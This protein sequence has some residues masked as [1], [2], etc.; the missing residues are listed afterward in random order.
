MVHSAR[1]DARRPDTPAA[2]KLVHLEAMRGIA[3]CFVVFFHF[4]MVFRLNHTPDNV[5][6]VNGIF[7]VS[8]FFALSGYVLSLGKVGVRSP[9]PWLKAAVKR[10]PRLAL[11]ALASVL[12][13]AA[14]VRQPIAPTPAIIAA[15]APPI[16][17]E[18][19]A[20]AGD[21]WLAAYQGVV[22]AFAFGISPA[23]PALWT[24]KVELIGSLGLFAGCWAAAWLGRWRWILFAGVATALYASALHGYLAFLLGRL[25]HERAFSATHIPAPLRPT[26][27][28]IASSLG[29]VLSSYPYDGYWQPSGPFFAKESPLWSFMP[30]VR[31]PFWFW[32]VIGAWLLLW[33]F[34]NAPAVSRIFSGWLSAWLGRL[35]FSI[36]LVHWPILATFVVFAAGKLKHLEYS[37][38]LAAT[39]AIFAVLTLAAS[40]P[41]HLLIDR[42]S[43]ALT[44][45][46]VARLF[47]RREPRPV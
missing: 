10:Y 33:V 37:L 3:A 40:V 46:V 29:V 25:L 16:V 23:N 47:R 36:Y 4:D 43:V 5:V 20:A 9:G 45:R 8:F 24:M 22:G 2:G 11:P 7:A 35:S 15:Y 27:F 42:P 12:I 28:L 38:A 17:R 44:N 21:P 13:A 32:R 14:L 18:L 30:T 1:D 26:A 39:F 31:D 34:V 6:L 19:Y 41:F